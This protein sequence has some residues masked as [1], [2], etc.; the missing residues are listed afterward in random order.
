MLELAALALTVGVVFA[1]IVAILI[2][3]VIVFL[4]WLL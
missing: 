1:V 4:Q 2:T 3:S